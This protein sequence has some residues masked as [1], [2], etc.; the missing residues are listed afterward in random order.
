MVVMGKV[1]AVVQVTIS[2][3]LVVP[4]WV[5]T[6]TREWIERLGLGNWSVRL[7]LALCIADDPL[8]RGSAEAAPNVHQATI[9]LRADII[10]TPDWRKTIIHELLH[11]AHGQVDQMVEESLIAQIA[12][13]ARM[14]A[15]GYYRN[16]MEPYIDQLAHTLYRAT[17][18]LDYPEE[19]GTL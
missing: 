15:Y 18:A 5:E 13:P 2:P 3:E 12:D 1:D 11:V 16:T 19:Y 14:L 4:A 10:D 8:T 7:Q 9:T 6:Y 17:C